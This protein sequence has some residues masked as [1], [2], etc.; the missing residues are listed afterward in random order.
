[1]GDLYDGFEEYYHSEL[2]QAPAEPAERIEPW[3]ETKIVGKSLPRVDA[4][5]RVSGAAQYTF[6]VM[7]PDMLYAATLRCPH[8][9]ARVKSIDTGA[10]EKMPG[11]RAV[12]TAKSAGADIPWYGGRNPQS[13][14]F[15]PHCR[16]Q[17]EEVAAVAAETPYQAK[18]AL[19][20]IK[21]E[22]EVLPFAHNEETALKADAPK[23]HE[24]GNRVGRPRE[25]GRGDVEKGFAEADIVLEE[26]FYTHVQIHVPMEAHSSVAKWDGDKLTIWD[27]TQGVYDAVHFPISRALRVPLNKVRV[28]C[29]YMGGGFGAKLELGKYSVM[30]ALLARST[31]RPV[32]I[33]LS[34]EETLLCVGNRPDAKMTLKAGVKNDGTLT[35][36]QLTNIATPGAYSSGTSVGFQVAELYRCSNVKITENAF[37][38]NAGKARPFRA[39][40]F[41]QCSWALEQMMDMLAEK[42]NMDPVELR[43]K[44]FT[45]FSQS[46]QMPYT[47]AG[48]KA[49]LE[50]GAK[51]FGWKEAKAARKPDGHIK[52]GVGLAGGTWSMGMGR[53]PYPAEVRMLYDGSVTIRTGAM[54]IGTGT[55][56]VACI[57]A[58]EELNVPLENVRI[59]NADTA[60][61]PY[62]QSS[63]GSMTLPGLIPAVRRGAFLVKKQLLGWAA[64]DL[65]VSADDLELKDNGV[66]SRTRPDKKKTIAELI[67]AQ[68]QMEVIAVGNR[69]PNPSNKRVIPFAAHF[70]EV[71]V[72]TK[73]GEIKVVRLVGANESGRV[74]NRKTFD[75]QVFGGMTQGVGFGLMEKRVLDRQTGK[76]ANLN[77]HD[78]KIPTSM[79]MPP[80]HKVVAIDPND[81][82][83]NIVGCKGLGEPAKI[84]A[85]A[86]VANAIYDA[87]G[88]RPTHGPVDPRTI[89]ELLAKGKRG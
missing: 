19:K 77:W 14:L 54:D 33:A 38:I 59:E 28:I 23:I 24:S 64:E 37:Y 61:H 15:D 46:S 12:L 17:G 40:G 47:S 79:D 5:D 78:Y 49:C 56:S 30:A 45:E 43:L 16:H 29:K 80:D 18:D 42:I 13:K 66:V 73:T 27:S 39:P 76:M 81:T 4:Y 20:A 8:A 6:D 25:S 1:M 88:V 10:A 85:A 36:L 48:L 75:N 3:K 87:I 60:T 65:G 2:E 41:P 55:K 62:A 44:N 32:K 31:G 35:A 72:N 26:T 11:V 21:V 84:P 71:E 22:Y 9:H 34:R 86:A 82:E 68:G 63:G 69:Q 58:A 83:C 53:P 52:R 7:L 70:A 67:R 50:E 51:A 74:I 57:T 89:L